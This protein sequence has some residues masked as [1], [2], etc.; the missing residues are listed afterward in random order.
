MSET[1]ISGMA[2]LGKE[3][4]EILYTLLSS[5]FQFVDFLPKMKIKLFGLVFKKYKKSLLQKLFIKSSSKLFPLYEILW[6]FIS[7]K[8][9]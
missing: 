6:K 2:G 7:L 5:G 3:T 1:A 8:Y 9:W 4:S